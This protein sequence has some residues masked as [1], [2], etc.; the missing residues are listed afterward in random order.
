MKERQV[1]YTNFSPLRQVSLSHFLHSPVLCVCVFFKR[2]TEEEMNTFIPYKL[3]MDNLKG[4]AV[5][6]ALTAVSMTATTS[7]AAAVTATT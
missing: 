5:T 7:L 3:A 2:K 1:L 6:A 4:T